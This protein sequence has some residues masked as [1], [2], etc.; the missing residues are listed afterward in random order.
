MSNTM[1]AAAL[2]E[3]TGVSIHEHLERQVAI[4]VHSGKPQRQGDVMFIPAA[5]LSAAKTPLTRAGYPVVVGENGGNTHRL[6][7][8]S[9]SSFYDPSTAGG[10]RL[11][12]LTVAEGGVALLSHPEH[13]FMAFGDGTYVV[14]RQREQADEIR[15]VQD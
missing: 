9:G 8:D 15:L 4:P 7:A 10:Q 5:A 2:E 13:G 1:T 11:G 14:T 12:V 3:R 6:H